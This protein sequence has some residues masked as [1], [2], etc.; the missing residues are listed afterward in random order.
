M[1]FDPGT[2]TEA[3]TGPVIVGITA[4]VMGVPIE[5][6]AQAQPAYDVRETFYRS[7]IRRTLAMEI[8]FPV[9]RKN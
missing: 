7:M 3:L 6:S 5:N 1:L 2:T 8:R 9:N 4:A